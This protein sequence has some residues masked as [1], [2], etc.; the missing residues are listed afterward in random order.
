MTLVKFVRIYAK[1]LR[2]QDAGLD[3]G[4][5]FPDG[6]NGKNQSFALVNNLQRPEQI[7]VKLKRAVCNFAECLKSL[8]KKGVPPEMSDLRSVRRA[9]LA[10]D[11]PH[12]PDADFIPA[13]APAEKIIQLGD[14][15]FR[16]DVISADRTGFL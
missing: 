2:V 3:T 4:G 7:V 14:G 16:C 10:A 13:Q 15:G 11:A 8:I 12:H 6:R 1:I 9:H 5:L